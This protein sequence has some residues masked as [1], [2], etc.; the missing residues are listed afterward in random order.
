MKH[1]N[2]ILLMTHNTKKS[3]QSILSLLL[4][5]G[6]I[7]LQRIYPDLPLEKIGYSIVF[8]GAL[9][10]FIDVILITSIGKVVSDARARYTMK[11]TLRIIFYVA[12]AI[13]LLRVWIINPEALLVAYGLIAAGVAVSL[14]DFFKNFAGGFILFISGI[15]AVGERIE[16]A[17]T[18]GDVIDIGVL[19]TK[20]IEIGGW[21]HGDQTTGRVVSI[22]NGHILTNPIHNYSQ[23]HPY[24]WDEII[25][26]ITHNSDVEKARA[27]LLKGALLETEKYMELARKS[28]EHLTIDYYVSSRSTQPK[29]YVAITDNWTELQLR[30]VVSAWERREVRSQIFTYISSEVQKVEDVVIASE[31]LTVSGA[32]V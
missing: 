24:L 17:G 1:S 19:Y 7:M 27:I 12:S 11:K 26:P 16:I 29:V 20:I 4:G 13:L 32:T 23:D 30:Y 14:A 28:L 5:A 18:K 21:V 22:P 10:L 25:I 15:Y 31:T 3:I 2:V 8:V 9:F 6:I